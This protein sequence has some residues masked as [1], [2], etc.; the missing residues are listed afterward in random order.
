MSDRM[1][2]KTPW[3]F[4]HPYTCPLLMWVQGIVRGQRWEFSQHS[5]WRL[6]ETPTVVAI[7]MWPFWLIDI[8]YRLWQRHFFLKAWVRMIRGRVANV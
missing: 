1:F 3:V 7:C 5:G 6:L 2:T 8:E 4:N